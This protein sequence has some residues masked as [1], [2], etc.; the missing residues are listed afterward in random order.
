MGVVKMSDYRDR[1]V[2][3]SRKVVRVRGLTEAETQKARFE[4]IMLIVSLWVVSAIGFLVWS[5]LR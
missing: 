5:I 4:I 2:P 3:R 1:E